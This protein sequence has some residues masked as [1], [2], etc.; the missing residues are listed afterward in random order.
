MEAYEKFISK[1][2]VEKIHEESLRILK[3][4]GIRFEHPQVIKI[5]K[6]HGLKTEGNTVFIDKKTVEDQLACIPKSFTIKSSKGDSEYGVGKCHKMPAAGNIFI[7]DNGVVRKMKN[8]DVINQFKLS[9]TSKLIDTNYMNVF[10]EEKTFTEEQKI[11]GTMAMHLKYSNKVGPYVLPNTFQVAEIHDPYVKGLKLIKEFEDKSEEYVCI[12]SINTLSPLCYDHDPLEKMLIAGEEN[13]PIWIS[14]CGMP[15]LTS[16]PSVMGMMAMTNAEILGGLV[17]AQMIKPGIPCV[18]G[19]ASGST[20]LRTIQL[21]IGS[22]ESVLVIYGTKALADYYGLPC[23][24]G[25]GL[26]D[27]KDF[28]FQAG[29]ESM[30]LI[31]ASL[32]ANPDLL[33]HACGI[34]GS[35]NIISFE[36]FLADEEL[37]LMCERILRGIDCSEEK[38]CFEMIKK[39]GPRGTFLK[40]RTP[41]MYRE[42]FYL[43]QY[44]NKAD[45]NQW[46]ESGAISLRESIGSKVEERI[47]SYEKPDIT[48]EQ[49]RLLSRYI[50]NEYQVKI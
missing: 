9:D 22:P 38:G 12:I 35:F 4:V 27:A 10:L 5:F 32:S 36:K 47:K 19:N 1:E 31:Y 14:P 24:A 6:E 20:D 16:P 17:L 21:C 23:R 7:Q 15:S 18:Y 28:D 39:T 26:S 30:M 41:K 3:E 13:Q 42:E 25:G 50:P 49:E 46:K 40:G 8:E 34:M 11:Y 29:S 45:P 48:K 43:S 2:D 37:Y 44:F 33:F